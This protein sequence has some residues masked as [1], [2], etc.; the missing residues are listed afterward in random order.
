[1]EQSRLSCFIRS[2]RKQD[3]FGKAF[4]VPK[5]PIYTYV[6]G[7]ILTDLQQNRLYSVNQLVSTLQITSLTFSKS[8]FQVNDIVAFIICYLAPPQKGRMI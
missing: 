7:D 5:E 8:L 1:M 3:I 2:D 4:D 6:R